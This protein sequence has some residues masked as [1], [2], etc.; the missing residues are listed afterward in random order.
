MV[1]LR[2]PWLAAKSFQHFFWTVLTILVIILLY[3]PRVD[4]G[5]G[6][7]LC[8]CPTFF[9]SFCVFIDLDSMHAPLMKPIPNKSMCLRVSRRGFRCLQSNKNGPK[10]PKSHTC[11][12]ISGASWVDEH[13]TFSTQSVLDRVSGA[14]CSDGTHLVVSSL[15]SH[16][17][18]CC[19]C[20]DK[21]ASDPSSRLFAYSYFLKRKHELCK[22]NSSKMYRMYCIV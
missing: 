6:L 1:W 21:P 12:S 15:C 18:C 16:L 22:H 11:I 13:F 14:V 9:F 17:C 20:A 2:Q 8:V 3:Y 7:D 19:C 5:Y 4:W 10:R